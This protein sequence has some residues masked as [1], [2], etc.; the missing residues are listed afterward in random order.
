MNKIVQLLILLFLSVASHA[1]IAFTPQSIA[2]A[3]EQSKATGKPVFVEIYADGCHHCEAFKRTFDTDKTVGEFYNQNFISYQVEVNS[4]EGRKFRKDLNIYVMSTPLFTFWETDSTLLNIVPAGDEQNNTASLLKIGNAV[5]DPASQWNTQKAAFA[6][7]KSDA[8]FLINTAYLARYTTDTTL[9]REAMQRYAQQEQENGFPEDY[10]LVLQKVIMDDENPLVLHALNNLETYYA[11][12]GKEEVNAALEN[13]IM[14]SLMSSR[15]ATFGA[16]KLGFMKMALAKIGVDK[17]SIN[18]RFLL[19]ETSYYFRNG[20][21]EKAIQLINDFFREIENPN[22]EEIN[23]IKEYVTK[24]TQNQSLISQ[25][26]WLFEK[27]TK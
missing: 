4:E 17:R 2:E 6:S 16:S 15:A 20:K 18:G 8:N 9:N 25:L 23:Y 5:L 19:P 21:D 11:N 7:G 24:N 10:F 1:Q 14:F 26:D 3:F 27:A 22:P 13:I 12:H